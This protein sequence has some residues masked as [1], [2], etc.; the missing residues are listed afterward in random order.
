MVFKVTGPTHT[1]FKI[2]KFKI[3]K[4]VAGSILGPR[5]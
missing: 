5:A 1:H 3:E 4:G 2:L